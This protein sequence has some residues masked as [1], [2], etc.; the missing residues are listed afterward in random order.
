ME[1]QKIFKKIKILQDLIK[2]PINNVVE[3]GKQTWEKSNKPIFY[4]FSNDFEINLRKMKNLNK[5]IEFI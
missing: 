3:N 4:S 5:R 1:F 2:K